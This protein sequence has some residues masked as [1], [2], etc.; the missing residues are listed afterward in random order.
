MFDVAHET[1]IEINHTPE[2]ATAERPIRLAFCGEIA[3]I[4]PSNVLRIELR[5]AIAGFPDRVL[6]VLSDGKEL[7]FNGASVDTADAV[8]ALLWP[9]S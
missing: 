3:W 1:K 6:L 9:A 5:K 7:V 2:A 8:A 4:R